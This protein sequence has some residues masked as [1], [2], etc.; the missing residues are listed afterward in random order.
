MT[1]H[2]LVRRALRVLAAT[3]HTAPIYLSGGRTRTLRERHR[4]H[5]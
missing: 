2:R 1:W 5:A 4:R 3:E